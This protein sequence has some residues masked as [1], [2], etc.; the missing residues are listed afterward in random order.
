MN[1]LV[2]ITLCKLKINTLMV[3][4]TQI[5]YVIGKNISFLGKKKRKEKKEF[6]LKIAFAVLIYYIS[7]LL[8]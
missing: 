5:L 2:F 3:I 4:H 6:S 7:K 8:I 1:N